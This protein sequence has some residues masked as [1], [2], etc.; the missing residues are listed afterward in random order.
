MATD[1][2]DVLISPRSGSWKWA[3]VLR[4]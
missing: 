1:A 2:S 3:S 4:A